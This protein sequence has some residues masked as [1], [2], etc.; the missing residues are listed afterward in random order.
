M[1]HDCPD[2]ETLAAFLD[3]TLPA[4][5]RERIQRHLA[6]CE[7]CYE[8]FAGAAAFHDEQLES[9]TAG[10]GV[11]RRAAL[12][13]AA[14]ALASI[15]LG[16]SF[17]LSTPG[18]SAPY[19]PRDVLVELLEDTDGGRLVHA[20]LTGGFPYGPPPARFRSRQPDPSTDPAR[21]ELFGVAA[22]INELAETNPTADNLAALGAAHLLV[23][24]PNDAIETLE[25]AAA[26]SSHDPRL[27]SDLGAAY[28]ERALKNDSSEDLIEAYELADRALAIDPT[29]LEAGFNRGLILQHLH[30]PSSAAEAW[31]SYLGLDPGSGWSTEAQEGLAGARRTLNRSEPTTTAGLLAAI[32]TPSEITPLV[33]RNPQQSRLLL[34]TEIIPRLASLIAETSSGALGEQAELQRLAQR[35]AELIGDQVLI[36]AVAELSSPSLH[37]RARLSELAAAHSA[38]ASARVDIIQRGPDAAVCGDLTRASDLFHQAGSDYGAWSEV[39]MSICRLYG[40]EDL[41]PIVRSLDSVAMV[42]EATGSQSLLGRATWHR[43]LARL[44]HDRPAAALGDYLEAVDLFES[45]GEAEHVAFLNSMIKDGYDVLG[46]RRRGWRYALMALSGLETLG[47]TDRTVRILIGAA[48]TAL[49]Q[50]HLEAADAFRRELELIDM[51]AISPLAIAEVRLVQAAVDVALG[52]PAEAERIIDLLGATPI[53]PRFEAEIAALRGK[54]LASDAP[55]E[56]VEQ[57]SAAIELFEQVGHSSRTAGLLTDR[58][59]AYRNA[60]ELTEARED[61]VAAVALLEGRAEEALAS[62][63]WAV[64]DDAGWRALDGLVGLQWGGNETT[65]WNQLERTRTLLR[66]GGQRVGSHLGAKP[67]TAK[68]LMEALPTDHAVISLAKTGH[69]VA[70]FVATRSGIRTEILRPSHDELATSIARFSEILAAGDWTREA[71]DLSRGLYED[72]VAP[73]IAASGGA[74]TLVFIQDPPLGSL[75]LAALQ[76]PKTGSFLIEDRALIQ[77]PSATAFVW[78]RTAL[79]Q[80]TGSLDTALVLGD[81]AFDRRLFPDLP[82]LPGAHSE[83]TSVGSLYR[84]SQVLVGTR[85]TATSLGRLAGQYSV[86]HIAAHG[87]TNNDAPERSAL[88]LAPDPEDLHGGVLFATD[89]LRLSLDHTQVVVL[90]ACNSASGSGV[91]MGGPSSLAG[92]FLAASVPSVIATLWR[93][94]DEPSARL[95][96]RLHESLSRGEPPALALRSAQLQMLESDDRVLR[97][98]STWAG[99]IALGG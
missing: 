90:S 1:P 27:M 11:G 97:A 73:A 81:P 7:T 24:N 23:G 34:Q 44:V 48:R 9:A 25:A 69:E 28:F 38:F 40:G 19:Q 79:Q 49:R 91:A 88:A 4:A 17:F 68:A 94:D 39:W 10:R 95:I 93:I 58:A 15:A 66:P 60:G 50:E 84:K 13:G 92:A 57:F 45:A 85:A 12:M 80:R 52:R 21:W 86:V 77:V 55:L 56:A 29:L 59:E 70:L 46:N 51:E 36:G 98:P 89:V 61:L 8:V 6:R 37:S 16:T 5:D 72:L 20:R 54:I 64:G 41:D 30:L 65:L 18:E 87:I 35:M 82:L 26:L 2:S 22:E 71:E 75:P 63:T 74:T 43:G 62:A 76:N 47:P 83:A 14:A 3:G 31:E 67:I 78:S 99:F 53:H 42:A 32:D 96:T 33:R